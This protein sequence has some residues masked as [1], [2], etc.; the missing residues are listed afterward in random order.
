[1]QELV[2]RRREREG[3]FS[4][5][6]RKMQESLEQAKND[7]KIHKELVNC[8]NLLSESITVASA[9]RE[10]RLVAVEKIKEFEERTKT[11]EEEKLRLEREMKGCFR[12]ENKKFEQRT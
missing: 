12:G 8:R 4:G 6:I 2:A 5:T 11:L 9:E 10:Q 7:E 3:G 1:M